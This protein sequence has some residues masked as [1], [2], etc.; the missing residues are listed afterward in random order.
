MANLRYSLVQ[1][2][3]RA[4]LTLFHGNTPLVANDEHPNWDAIIKG[5]TVDDDPAVA[6]LFDITRTVAEKFQ[7]LGSRVV[8]RDNRIYFDGDEVNNTLSKKIMEFVEAGVEDWKP[9]VRFMEKVFD[10]PEEHSRKQLFDWLQN[11]AFAINED[12][13]ILGYK[14][15]QNYV[16]YNEKRSKFT[17]ESVHSGLNHVTVDDQVFTGR[18]PQSVGS[19]V[20]MARSEVAFDPAEGCGAGLH[21]ANFR[22]ANGWG[23]V[24]LL[25]AVSPRDVVSVPTES[26]WEKVRV[27]RYRVVEVVDHDK[28]RYED[29][30]PLHRE[31]P[32]PDPELAEDLVPQVGDVVKVYK[33]EWICGGTR[34]YDDLVT[35]GM[36]SNKRYVIVSIHPENASSMSGNAQVKPEDNVG[37]GFFVATD[38][39]I[40]LERPKNVPAVEDDYDD[41]D[42]SWSWDDD[43]DDPYSW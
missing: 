8:A 41:E 25:V 32:E 28:A 2:D 16:G 33:D 40:V 38:A 22:Y 18:V 29:V 43:D 19:V 4:T 3:G 42:D 37:H 13:D 20:E 26:N 17:F 34:V 9:L 24:V 31:T 14:G 6:D 10:N 7:R 30:N 39:L 35:Y 5:V 11:H 27:C 12:G 15:V 23:P 36:D 21:V 1:F